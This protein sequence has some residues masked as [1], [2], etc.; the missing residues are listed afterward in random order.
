MI[1]ISVT[2]LMPVFKPFISAVLSNVIGTHQFKRL[3]VTQ[4]VRPFPDLW[5]NGM[6]KIKNE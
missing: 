5:S 3:D 4:S 6:E 2:I 1:S